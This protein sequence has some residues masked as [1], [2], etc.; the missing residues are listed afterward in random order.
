MT[1]KKPKTKR[2]FV[3]I[4]ESGDPGFPGL[5]GA[6]Q[7][8]VLVVDEN[9]MPALEREISLYK[10]FLD[11]YGELKKRANI[12]NEKIAHLLEKVE[13]I[14]GVQF[15]YTK[16]NKEKYK[17]PYQDNPTYFRNLIIKRT[18]QHIRKPT[19]VHDG[20]ELEIVIDRYLDSA[21]GEK[22]LKTYLN[23]GYL[24][25][26]FLH[27]EQ[28]DSRYCHFIQILDILGTFCSKNVTDVGTEIS[29]V[30][31]RKEKGPDAS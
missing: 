23:D 3:F 6:F 17:G 24:L 31:G 10:Y 2:R 25:P 18:L 8:N 19:L 28:V 9:K 11:H 4:D 20:A 30:L 27:I 29:L 5:S 12:K 14:S 7:L 26:K 15:F 22:N 13:G 21:E 1:N 16:T